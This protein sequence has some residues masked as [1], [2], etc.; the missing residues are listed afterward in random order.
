MPRSTMFDDV[1]N[2]LAI[3]IDETANKIALA[4]AP[5]QAPFAATLTEDQKLAVYRRLLFNDDG[6]PNEAGR[7]KEQ[8][9][10]GPEGLA[11]VYKAVLR[12]YPE[13]KPP[14]QDPD[15]IEALAPMPPPMPPGPPPGMPPMPPGPPPG[16]PP[17]LPPG[18]M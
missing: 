8:A 9:R 2:D 16:P 11:Q 17:M 4:L 13:L 15:S 14:E 10:L 12:R 7:A 1:A 6:S 18:G 3:W 5:R